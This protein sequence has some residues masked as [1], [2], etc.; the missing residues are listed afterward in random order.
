MIALLFSVL[1]FVRRPAPPRRLGRLIRRSPLRLEELEPRIVLSIAPSPLTV[2]APDYTVVPLA[3][4]AAA[5]YSPAQIR[6]AYGFNRLPYDGTGQTIAIVDAYDDPRILSDL[7]Y[8]DRTWGLSD[9]PSFVKTTPPVNGKPQPLPPSNADW[10]GEISLDV[11]WA[12]AIAPRAKI[13]LVEAASASGADLLS[14]V[15]YARNQPGVAA[16]SMSWG[17][18]E[19]STEAAYDS[20]FTTPAGHGGVVF[21]AASGDGGAG[22]QWPAVSPNVLAV[23]GTGLSIDASGNYLGETGWADSGGGPSRFETEPGFQRAVQQSGRRS[24][25][26]VAYNADPNTGFYVYDTALAVDGHTGWFGYGGTSAGAPQWAAL[27]ALADQGRAAAGFAPLANGPAALYSLSVADFH[28]VKAGNNGFQ[29]A[30]GYDLVTGLGSPLANLVV[31]DLVRYGQM[32]ASG[33]R[34]PQVKTATPTGHIAAAIQENGPAGYT[35]A[36]TESGGRG[37]PAV[38]ELRRGPRARRPRPSEG[39]AD[40]A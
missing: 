21:V 8:F 39:E 40:L 34:S 28:D 30:A 22:A 36:G 37:G 25:P 32:S 11:E 26:D 13:L 27:I 19:F 16:V 2:I 20:T 9:P 14:A 15:D 10:S 12:H 18:S 33:A 6:V 5:P 35:T 3:V 29:A 1:R 23:G 7:Q 17:G 31:A 38:A 24:T 4:A